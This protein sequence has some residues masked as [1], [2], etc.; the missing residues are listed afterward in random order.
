MTTSVSLPDNICALLVNDVP[1]RCAVLR[2]LLNKVGV[3][4][5]RQATTRSEVLR[6]L[7]DAPI[8][9][10]LLASACSFD[11]IQMA[12]EIRASNTRPYVPIILI[13]DEVDG[14]QALSARDS[15]VTD[16]LPRPFTLLG[17]TQCLA[18]TVVGNRA[19]QPASPPISTKPTLA[20]SAKAA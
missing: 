18:N 6:E 8:D 9:I 20:K 10:I 13:V 3:S 1:S 16:F 19:R 14:P 15:G 2:E 5:I 7:N 11:A 12:R 17:M 4:D